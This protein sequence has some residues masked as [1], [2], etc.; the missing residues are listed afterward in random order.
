[1]DY[2]NL[3]FSGCGMAEPV[4]VTY[5]AGLEM[6]AFVSDYDYNAP[7]KEYLQNTH[8]RLYDIIRQ[9]QPELPYIILSKPDIDREPKDGRKRREIIY[10]SYQ[11]AVNGG[12]C[13]VYFIDGERLFGGNER[14]ACTVDGIHPNDL[15]FYRMAETIGSVLA[16]IL[17]KQEEL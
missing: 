17:K 7:D 13:H 3:G 5:M 8:K 14:E 15:G 2:I 4:I 11:E 16:R 12:D 10:A 9:K 6:Q 1:M